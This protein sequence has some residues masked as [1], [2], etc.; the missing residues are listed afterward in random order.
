[1]C[2][3]LSPRRAGEGGVT[4]DRGRSGDTAQAFVSDWSPDGKKL[5]FAGRPESPDS[6]ASA[7][8]PVAPPDVTYVAALRADLG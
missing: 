1:M 4:V 3:S 8:A 6:F 5:V 7:M 2:A